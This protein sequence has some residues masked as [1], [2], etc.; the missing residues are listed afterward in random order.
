MSYGPAW[1]LWI[2]SDV[3]A[4]LSRLDDQRKD[5][6]M[7]KTLQTA[8]MP[9]VRAARQPALLALAALGVVYGDIGTSTLY[10]L[11]QAVEAGGTPTPESVLGIV[12]VILWSLLLVVGLKYA[13]LILRADN[14][15][16]GGIVALLA[17]LDVRRAPSGS[18][19]ASLLVVGL[20][21]AALL[22]GDGVITPAISVLS[23]VEGLRIDAPGLAPIVVPIT[24]A[25][26]VGLFLVQH[27]G[28]DF[29]GNIFGPV[30]LVWFVAI[31]L[32]GLTGIMRAPGILAAI[33]PY[34]AVFYLVHVG[35]GIAFAVLGAAF[36]AL[37][38]AEAMYADMGHFGRLP[39][40]LGWF[41]VVLP[42][43]MLNYFGQ[44][45]LLLADPSAV[46]NPFYLLAP[47][48]A[49]YPMVAFATM[50]TVI[51]SQSIISGAYSLTQ[52]AMQLGFLPRMR[53][54]HTASHEKG[55]IY[56]PVV[57][58]LLAAGT[59]A[60][61]LTFGSSDALGGAYGIA[62]SMLMAV[63]T[64]L[65]ALVALQWG[66]N[67][68]LVALVNG[69]F[70]AI[71][72][73]FVAANMT[74]LVEGGWFPLLLASVIAFLM[75]TWRTGWLLLERE[76]AKLR[77]HEAEFVTWVLDS[78]PIRLPGAAAIFTAAS[79]GIPLGLTHHLRHN[80]VLHERVLLIASI[81]TDEPRVAPE[82][83][84]RLVPVG[85]G[86][87]RVLFH[88]GFM[89]TPDVMAGLKLAC[90]EPE[91]HGID[92]QNIT[93]YFRRVMVIPGKGRGMATWRKS[94]FAT[95]HLN[96]NLPAAY[97]GV[98]AAQVVEVGL[99]VEI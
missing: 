27:K 25:I 50:A 92:P 35:P 93:Y 10:G 48:W 42:A 52:Q 34:H 59:L 23:A 7:G 67:P 79:T 41:S 15:G 8:G 40:Q 69:F 21:G 39:I 64:I 9:S 81:I 55:Q 22:Y 94:L 90:L 1:E 47:R 95:M 97:F 51:A 96:A 16:E 75:L 63:T 68:V 43:L 49:H 89:E 74:K 86:I 17:L 20:I 77:Q 83:R 5:I 18:W 32:L 36:L 80:R 45:G 54:Q 71:E 6:R 87:T 70:L 14:H 65:A 24:V 72:L 46:E 13:I 33:N 29:I 62:V 61:V 88:F 58:W 76:R 91:L 78:P 3:P 56:I 82:R 19:R 12:S 73:I 26:L 31:G 60:A 44:G 11:K 57:N 2:A 37:T 85:A 28:T 99:E 4:D 98:P 53:V 30:M 38:G 84:I 66:Y